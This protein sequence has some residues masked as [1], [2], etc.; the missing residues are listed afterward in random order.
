METSLRLSS[1]DY[2]VGTVWFP[3]FRDRLLRFVFGLWT[4]ICWVTTFALCRV[5]GCVS[6]YPQNVV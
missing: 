6:C 3:G 5:E 2:L 4:V 1:R